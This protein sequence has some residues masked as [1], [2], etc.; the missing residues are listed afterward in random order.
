MNQIQVQM[1]C[2]K[3]LQ[4]LLT[5]LFYPVVSC[6]IISKSALFENTGFR[7]QLDF[8]SNGAI[9]FKG[10]PHQRLTERASVDFRRV[11]GGDS[12]INTFIHE[13]GQFFCRPFP[14]VQPPESLNHG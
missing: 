13:S 2:M 3:P 4:A 5:G 9:L 10:L 1:V 14:A 11:K 8:V 12:P 7:Y 6:V